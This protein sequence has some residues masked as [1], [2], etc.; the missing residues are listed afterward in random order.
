MNFNQRVGRAFDRTGLAR[1]AQQAAHQRGLAGAEVAFEPDH[2]ARRQVRCEPG[3]EG[4]GI[5]FT[6]QG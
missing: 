2:A 6:G 4:Q 1:R 5:G 3:A